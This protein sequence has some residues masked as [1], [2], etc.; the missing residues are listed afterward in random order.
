MHFDLEEVFSLTEKE[1][2]FS[3]GEVFILSNYV[4]SATITRA[5]DWLVVVITLHSSIF[6]SY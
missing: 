4:S 3:S 1:I 2:S 5:Q 6:G